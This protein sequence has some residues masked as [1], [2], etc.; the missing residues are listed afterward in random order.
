MKYI[1]LLKSSTDEEFAEIIA[2]DDIFNMACVE[3]YNFDNNSCKYGKVDCYK[4]ILSLLRSEIEEDI[5]KRT[6]QD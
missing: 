5:V 4:C 3:N 6:M 2:N 1:D